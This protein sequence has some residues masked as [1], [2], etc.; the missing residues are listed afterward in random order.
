M[1]EG[2]NFEI[3]PPNFLADSNREP[4]LITIY[5]MN[6]HDC[7]ENLNSLPISYNVKYS[8]ISFSHSTSPKYCLKNEPVLIVY[9][10][11]VC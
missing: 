9:L 8:T 7:T 3:F 1:G 11:G 4:P 6:Y 2:G 5:A 10:S